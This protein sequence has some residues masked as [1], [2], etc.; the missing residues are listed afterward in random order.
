MGRM[1]ENWVDT[2][3]TGRTREYCMGQ[4]DIAAIKV[5]KN[6]PDEV[7][8]YVAELTISRCVGRGNHKLRLNEDEVVRFGKM[9]LSLCPEKELKQIAVEVLNR[10]PEQQVLQVLAAGLKKWGPKGT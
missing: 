2:S 10:L 1:T 6:S 3:R 4:V 8:D 9:F 5:R 7:L